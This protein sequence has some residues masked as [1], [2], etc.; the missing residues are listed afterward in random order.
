MTTERFAD[1]CLGCIFSK[2]SPSSE[3]GYRQSGC[4]I[5]RLD[6]LQELGLATLSGTAVGCMDEYYQLRKRCN[7]KAPETENEDLPLAHVIDRVRAERR[8]KVAAIILLDQE[9][10][11]ASSMGLTKSL[12][13]I[14]SMWSVQGKSVPLYE[15]VFL[16]NNR[17]GILPGIL[18]DSLESDASFANHPACQVVHLLREATNLQ[19]VDEAVLRI[20]S[21]SFYV[22]LTNKKG[23]WGGPWVDTVPGVLNHLV[24]EECRPFVAVKPK[25]GVLN[26]LVAHTMTHRRD[27]VGGNAMM[28]FKD[29]V[30]SE[31][32]ALSLISDKLERLSLEWN[33]PGLVEPFSVLER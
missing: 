14:I 12:S 16:L 6:K 10:T 11:P 18:Q 22:V 13:R 17:S 21:S 19:A 30:E 26:G 2:L 33:I 28:G 5:G 27:K 1:N 29:S 25:D 20:K 24:N 4:D 23:D 3:D 9:T 31:E 32:V 7:Y 15:E 8:V